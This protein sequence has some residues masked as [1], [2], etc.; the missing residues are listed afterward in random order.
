MTWNVEVEISFARSQSS[1]REMLN[2]KKKYIANFMIYIYLCVLLMIAP[3]H[4]SH[5]FR[6]LDFVLES[7]F[8]IVFL[9]IM[10]GSKMFI[11]LLLSLY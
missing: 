9:L 1:Y 2:R 5:C 7:K 10:P 4:T 11:R 6:F 8:L 3:N